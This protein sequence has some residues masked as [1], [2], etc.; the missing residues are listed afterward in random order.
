MQAT[1][2]KKDELFFILKMLMLVGGLW[3]LLLVPMVALAVMLLPFSLHP[4]E[5]ATKSFYEIFIPV[6]KVLSFVSFDSVIIYTFV[7]LTEM[8]SGKLK[9]HL[10]EK[11]SCP[12]KWMS[13]NIKEVN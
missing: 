7:L 8:F 13:R 1:I 6:S 4:I 10:E 11:G 5:D 12:F 3:F 2:T 9:S